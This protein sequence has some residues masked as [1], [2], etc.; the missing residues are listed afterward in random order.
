MYSDSVI[1]T[2]GFFTSYSEY[3]DELA[4]GVSWILRSTGDGKYREIFD[5]IAEAE[6]GE[7]DPEFKGGWVDKD[8]Q[9]DCQSLID[10]MFKGNKINKNITDIISC[11]LEYIKENIFK[12]K[13]AIYILSIR[14]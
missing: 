5:K 11:I 8:V 9:G 6:Y 4:W 3:T 2:Q 7:Q 1:E 13:F 14:K 10:K 12:K